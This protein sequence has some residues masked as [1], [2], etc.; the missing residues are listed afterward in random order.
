M[1][2]GSWLVDG[3]HDGILKGHLRP[4]ASNVCKIRT[5]LHYPVP[6]IK[7][8][9]GKYCDGK[10]CNGKYCITEAP[11]SLFNYYSG[12]WGIEYCRGCDI[13]ARIA[14]RT[15]PSYLTKYDLTCPITPHV[16]DVSA[17]PKVI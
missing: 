15:C 1:M 13:I 8:I 9:N 17:V 16:T 12:T 7:V 6:K 3:E 14:L 4:L 11:C 2:L 10:Y 5:E